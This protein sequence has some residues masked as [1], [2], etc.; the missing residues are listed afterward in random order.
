VTNPKDFGA[1]VC[2]ARR[3]RRMSLHDLAA[4]ADVPWAQ[5]GD[6]ERGIINTLGTEADARLRAVLAAPLTRRITP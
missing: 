3:K 5:L 6:L 1:S 2:I 4:A